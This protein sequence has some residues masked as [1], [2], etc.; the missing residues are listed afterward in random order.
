MQF[1]IKKGE[2]LS[3]RKMLPSSDE[4]VS[5]KLSGT[6]VTGLQITFSTVNN[7]SRSEAINERFKTGIPATGYNLVQFT[8]RPVSDDLVIT[9]SID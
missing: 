4:T 1:T 7:G 2:K 5:V 6:D 9:L 3:E 8:S